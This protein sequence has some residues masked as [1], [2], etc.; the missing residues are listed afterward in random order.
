MGRGLLLIVFL[1]PSCVSAPPAPPPHVGRLA[2]DLATFH[3][4]DLV[5]D[6]QPSIAHCASVREVLRFLGTSKA[7]P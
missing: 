1:A 2:L 5:C 6:G 7:A 3:E 4:D